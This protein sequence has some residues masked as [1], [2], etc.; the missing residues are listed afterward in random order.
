MIEQC[1]I[2]LTRQNNKPEKVFKRFEFVI[3]VIRLVL[4]WDHQYPAPVPAPDSPGRGGPT[5]CWRLRG[6]WWRDFQWRHQQWWYPPYNMY[7]Y[8]NPAS[9]DYSTNSMWGISNWGT[10][11]GSRGGIPSSGIPLG[12]ICFRSS[13]ISFRKSS[14]GSLTGFGWDKPNREIVRIRKMVNF[15]LINSEDLCQTFALYILI[16]TGLS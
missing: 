10:S 5:S 14:T 6:F 12:I 16:L 1:S 7:F 11:K 15:I 13:K 4:P 3:G 9:A 8:N 2:Y